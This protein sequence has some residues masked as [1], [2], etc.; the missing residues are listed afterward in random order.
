MAPLRIGM[1]DR[2]FLSNRRPILEDIAFAAAHELRTI[3]FHG[4]AAGLGSEQLIEQPATVGAAL[5]AAGVAAVMEILI[6]IDRNARAESSQS[7]LDI[8]Q[9]N[10]PAIRALGCVHVHWHLALRERLDQAAIDQIEVAIVPECAAAVALAEANGFRFAIE[11]NEPAVRPLHTPERAAA[12]L[13]AVPGLGLVWDL[14]HAAPE[15]VAGYL[16]L[17]PRITMLHVADTPL[18][19]VN[20]HLPIGL[21]TIDFGYYLAEL[22]R[23]G[24]SGPAILEIGGL[25]KSGGY[26]RDSDEALITSRERLL[27]AIAEPR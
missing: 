21:G 22:L 5:R 2:L 3:Q 13:D 12:L 14:N 6:Y 27:A 11:H 1:N 19:E 23:R 16:A 7:L 15:Q 4:T 26:G 17:T 25:P 20:H 18:P 8:L 24:F 9:A 10:M